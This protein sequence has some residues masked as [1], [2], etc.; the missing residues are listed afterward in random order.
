M[1]RRY[2]LI[3]FFILLLLYAFFV[4]NPLI[5]ENNKESIKSKSFVNSKK[6]DKIKPFNHL[7]FDNGNWKVCVI[8]NERYNIYNPRG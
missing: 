5:I 2:V 1:T 8:I 4:F 6:G 3:I 7:D